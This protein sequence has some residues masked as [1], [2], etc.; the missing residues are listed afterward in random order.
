[1]HVHAMSRHQQHIPPIQMPPKTTPRPSVRRSTREHAST[2]A[3][4]ANRTN[5]NQE[6]SETENPGFQGGGSDREELLEDGADED[7]GLLLNE[8]RKN[9][10]ERARLAEIELRMEA[11]LRRNLQLVDV[12]RHSTSSAQEWTSF[13]NNVPKYREEDDI[14]DWVET[15]IR[16]RP[17]GSEPPLF[18]KKLSLRFPP[19]F[20][21]T[22]ADIWADTAE[23]SSGE[24]RLNDAFKRLRHYFGDGATSSAVFRDI[25]DFQ[26]SKGESTARLISRFR[27]L[28]QK[29]KRKCVDEGM[30]PHDPN[31]SIFK[32]AFMKGAEVLEHFELPDLLEE[33]FAK[34]KAYLRRASMARSKRDQTAASALQRNVRGV[35]AVEPDPMSAIITRLDMMEQK[36]EHSLVKM[37]NDMNTKVVAMSSLLDRKR[38]EPQPKRQRAAPE[39]QAPGE[40]PAC[41]MFQ[42]RD[43][44]RNGAN[45]LYLHGNGEGQLQCKRGSSCKT[46][47]CRFVH[48]HS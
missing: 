6:H 41:L 21:D 1:M 15:A 46:R 40:G 13:A 43:G 9:A 24:S 27:S 34:T 42:T 25:M 31:A 30:T 3:A 22:L 18:W 5:R 37:R 12:I 23:R 47:N 2:A 17:D 32:E 7:D 28:M 14:D 26:K 29:Y 11:E 38:S 44:C 19:S 16:H 33:A 45:C 35:H 48:H 39:Q 8:Q 4:D 10:E 36:L 20:H